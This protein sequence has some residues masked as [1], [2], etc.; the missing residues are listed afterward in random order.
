MGKQRA[1]RALLCF[2]SLLPYGV[3]FYFIYHDVRLRH[4]RRPRSVG[5]LRL[6]TYYVYVTVTPDLWSPE[7]FAY[8]PQVAP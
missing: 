1:C 3:N 6:R 8:Q 4:A 5:R 2:I 7:G